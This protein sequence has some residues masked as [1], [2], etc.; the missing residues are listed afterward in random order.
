MQLLDQVLNNALQ[1]PFSAPPPGRLRRAQRNNSRG[2]A[3]QHEQEED[4]EISNDFA[5]PLLSKTQVVSIEELYK[6]S[7]N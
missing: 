7:G 6:H 2:K 5:L 3:Q 1:K 4:G